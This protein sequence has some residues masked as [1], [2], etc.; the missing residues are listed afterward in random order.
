ML[1]EIHWHLSVFV[2]CV[3]NGNQHNDSGSS[4]KSICFI[5]E[6]KK[7]QVFQLVFG[8]NTNLKFDSD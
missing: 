2:S 7:V 4:K 6:K 1:F 8:C 5:P 3:N